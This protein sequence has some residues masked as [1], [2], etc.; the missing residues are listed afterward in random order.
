VYLEGVSGGVV[1]GDEYSVPVFQGSGYQLVDGLS[2]LVVS[3]G[4]LADGDVQAECRG[5]V[6]WGCPCPGGLRVRGTDLR[7]AFWGVG[8][9]GE[10]VALVG[11]DGPYLSGGVDQ[12]EGVPFWVKPSVGPRAISWLCLLSLIPWRVRILVQSRR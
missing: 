7:G 2:E 4:G 6:H 3:A 8:P 9:E 11:E 5:F 1:L 12:P 10:D